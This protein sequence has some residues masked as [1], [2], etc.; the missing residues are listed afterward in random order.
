MGFNTMLGTVRWENFELSKD[1]LA[2]RSLKWFLQLREVTIFASSCFGSDHLEMAPLIAW[3]S[4]KTH[5]ANNDHI[6]YSSYFPAS[7]KANPRL[8]RHMMARNSPSTL[9]ASGAL[10]IFQEECFNTVEQP[11]IQHR[12]TGF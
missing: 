8:F 7:V 2:S 4:S 12:N 6:I 11:F 10:S 1:A 3:Y 5:P 9:T